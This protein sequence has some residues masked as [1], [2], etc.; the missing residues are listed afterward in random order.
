MTVF[1]H[2]FLMIEAFALI[3]LGSRQILHG[4]PPTHGTEKKA[5]I[6]IPHLFKGVLLLAAGVYFF[7]VMFPCDIGTSGVA[8]IFMVCYQVTEIAASIFSVPP[9]DG[10][11]RLAT[12][13]WVVLSTLVLISCLF[14]YWQTTVV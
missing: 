10:R 11:S 6:L 5:V 9:D 2:L 1:E 14:I 13:G 7:F 3:R 8:T 4:T 12:I